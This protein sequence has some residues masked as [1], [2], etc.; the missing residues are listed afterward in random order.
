M[1][2]DN[3]NN[4]HQGVGRSGLLRRRLS[5]EPHRTTHGR[6]RSASSGSRAAFLLRLLVSPLRASSW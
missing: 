2:E 5:I 3:T 6:L 4:P 1:K